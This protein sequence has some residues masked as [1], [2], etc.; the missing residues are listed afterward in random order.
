M[1]FSTILKAGFH[2]ITGAVGS[3]M[4][5]GT[6]AGAAYNLATTDATEPTAVLASALRGGILGGLAGG[7]SRFVTPK[8]AGGFAA[9][10]AMGI[11]A[12]VAG[13]GIYGA[14]KFALG[15][16][17]F[18]FKHPIVAAGIVGG[19]ALSTTDMMQSPYTSPGMS[20]MRTGRSMRNQQ[21]M[22]STQ[23]LVQGLHR[24]RH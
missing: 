3:R 6:L 13:L 18:A 23:G 12:G 15:A 5:F 24:S 4:A 14:S 8:L 22:Q 20:R 7:A 19:G 21:M 11:T 1:V 10:K 16:A 9:P 2:G 17:K